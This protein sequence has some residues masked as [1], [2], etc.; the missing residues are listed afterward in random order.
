M[1]YS[2]KKRPT[3][4]DS[5][6]LNSMSKFKA[7]ELGEKIKQVKHVWKVWDRK[8]IIE[9]QKIQAHKYQNNK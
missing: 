1:Q 5:T 2:G 8:E 9:N 7:L 3:T 6:G 4:S